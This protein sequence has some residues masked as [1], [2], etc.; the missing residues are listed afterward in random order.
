[1]YGRGPEFKPLSKLG[2]TIIGMVSKVGLTIGMVSKV[3]LTMPLSRH[4]Q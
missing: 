3:G 2:L 4:G 1:M